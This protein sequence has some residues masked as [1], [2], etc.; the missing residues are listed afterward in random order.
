MRVKTLASLQASKSPVVHLVKCWHCGKQFDLLNATWCGCGVH[1]DRPSKRCPFC[2]QC[3]CLHPDYTNEALWG[4][5]PRYL[6]QQGFEKLFY[7]YL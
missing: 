7:L 5:A 2:F 6:Q 3:I 4:R 1:V